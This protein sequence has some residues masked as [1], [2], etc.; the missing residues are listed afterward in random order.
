MKTSKFDYRVYVSDVKVSDY[1]K[2][3][4]VDCVTLAEAR[5][6]ARRHPFA[7]IIC[8]GEIEYFNGIEKD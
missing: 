4:Y 1:G 8:M 7:C 6:V 5:C 2:C 3:G